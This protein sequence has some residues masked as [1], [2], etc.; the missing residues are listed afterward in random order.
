[1]SSETW[2]I[3][4]VLGGVLGLDAV[5]FPQIMIARPLVA[6]ALGGLLAG[7]VA[8]G[9]WVG[10]LLEIISMRQLPMGGARY[11]DTGPAAFAAGLAYAELGPSASALLVATAAGLVF[12]WAG[13]WT[14]QW[15]RAWNTRLV[16]PLAGGATPPR[17]LV[18]RHL[19]ALGLDFLRAAVLTGLWIPLA[20]ALL[21]GVGGSGRL[22]A[23][24]AVLVVWAVAGAVGA[25][26]R[27]FTRGARLW[28]AFGVGAV[29]SALG[30]WWWT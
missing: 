28:Q 1:V 21:G 2:A 16:G 3:A 20:R 15:Q 18:R 29:V 10:A 5:S 24:A 26:L 19:G 7:D 30:V 27:T 25:A 6:G 22:A 4:A 13:S 12:G 11:H 23:L 14:V 8:L 9:L 17:R